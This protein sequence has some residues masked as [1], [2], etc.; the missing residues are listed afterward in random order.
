M[1]IFT[2]DY[3]VDGIADCVKPYQNT[4]TLC[5]YIV[6]LHNCNNFSEVVLRNFHMWVCIFSPIWY[7]RLSPCVPSL[8]PS[9]ELLLEESLEHFSTTR[10]KTDDK[11]SQA[12]SPAWQSRAWQTWKWLIYVWWTSLMTDCFQFHYTGEVAYSDTGYSDI[13]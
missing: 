9:D 5:T 13:V 7:N 11:G 3:F 10:T 4:S 2:D 6:P 12:L 8:P 1:W